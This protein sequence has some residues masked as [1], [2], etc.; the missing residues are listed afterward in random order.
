M[1]VLKMD[2]E[3]S[4]FVAQKVAYKTADGRQGI[5]GILPAGT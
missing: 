3:R 1:G 4:P 2:F 5:L